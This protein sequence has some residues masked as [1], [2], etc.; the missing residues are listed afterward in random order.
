MTEVICMVEGCDRP[1]RSRDWCLMHYTRWKRTG[2]LLRKAEDPDA[3]AARFLS[4]IDRRLPDECWPWLGTI[5]GN[6]YGQFGARGRRHSA[7]RYAYEFFVGPIPAGLTIDHVKARGC[8]LKHCVNPAHLEPVT[9]Q[10]NLRRS[11]A[12]SAVNARKTC[13]PR[14]GSDF[15]RSRDGRRYCKPCRRGWSK[16]AK[17]AS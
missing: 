4:K 14:C 8:R 11:D 5:L 6:G 15:D 16:G 1:V 2:S 10:E 9:M 3:I 13:C 17:H 7:H 12:V